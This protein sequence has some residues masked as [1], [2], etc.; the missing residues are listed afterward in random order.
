MLGNNR[1][2][3]QRA[4]SQL[5]ADFPIEDFDAWLLSG[6]PLFDIELRGIVDRASLA[7][8]LRS[9]EAYSAEQQ[10]SVKWVED[11]SWLDENVVRV[12]TR[13]TLITPST[14]RIRPFYG[15]SHDLFKRLVAEVL[16]PLHREVGIVTVRMGGYVNRRI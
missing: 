16:V 14:S 6:R 2:N 4:D 15:G 3:A 12:E 10:S 5:M 7:A 13:P 11:V 9:I 1:R 8:R